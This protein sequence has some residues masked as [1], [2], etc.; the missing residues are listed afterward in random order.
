MLYLNGLMTEQVLNLQEMPNA[1]PGLAGQMACSD[2]P[3][4]LCENC[5]SSLNQGGFSVHLDP[6]ELPSR[7]HALCRSTKIME[8]EVLD[9]E[10]MVRA[11]S[12]A[13]AAANE[14]LSGKSPSS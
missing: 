14:I 13:K 9:D 12:A 10:G 7:G 11:L 4:A 6:N 1:L 5:A 3:W 2:T 8:F